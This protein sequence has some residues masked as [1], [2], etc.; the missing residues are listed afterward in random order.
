MDTGA[1]GQGVETYDLI[2]S[3]P[4]Q[5]DCGL[6]DHFYLLKSFMGG[7]NT[8]LLIKSM[9]FSDHDSIKFQIIFDP[10]V[11]KFKKQKQPPEMLSKKV[12]LKKRL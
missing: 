5:L 2:V 11:T 7:K 4:V 1:L 3:G 6:V 10:Y 9:Y 12:L 8:A